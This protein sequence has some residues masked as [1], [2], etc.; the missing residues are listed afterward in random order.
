MALV[1]PC[2]AKLRELCWDV[3]RKT[4]RK[5]CAYAANAGDEVSLKKGLDVARA[6]F[7]DPEVLIYNAAS[8]ILDSPTQVPVDRLVDEFRVSV[9][10]ALV[11]AQDVAP[12]MIQATKGTIAFTGG[13]FAY[14]PAM[15][16]ASLQ[17]SKANGRAT[18][19]GRGE[20]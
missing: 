8:S 10:G 2:P 4:G 3:S 7:G 20:E 11:A 5:V 16:S 9:G 17:L 15:Q 18:C 14:E 19:R 6:D 1:V 13:V 12:A